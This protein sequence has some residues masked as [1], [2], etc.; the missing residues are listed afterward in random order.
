MAPSNH[1][2]VAMYVY[3]N[4]QGNIFSLA[5]S[6][7]SITV[8]YDKS[9][10]QDLPNLQ[11]SDALA[12]QIGWTERRMHTQRQADSSIDSWIDRQMVKYI[13]YLMFQNIEA[14]TM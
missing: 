8:S 7:T 11:P 4:I 6:M 12:L 1:L 2:L 5:N 10:K 9:V 13:Y 14:E 3:Y